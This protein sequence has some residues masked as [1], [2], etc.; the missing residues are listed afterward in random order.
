MPRFIGRLELP[1]DPP[2]FHQLCRV[3]RHHLRR[4]PTDQVVVGLSGGADSLAL[5]AAALAEQVEVHAVCVDHQ[6][7]P[8][9]GAVAEQAAATARHL[10][11]SAEVVRVNVDKRGS[12]EASARRARYA[13]LRQVAAGRP[14]WVGHTGDDQAETLLLRAAR[15]TAAG[16][17]PVAGQVHRPLLPQP[18]SATLAACAEL[19]LTPWQDPQ[20][21]DEA[22]ARVGV[23]RRVI[24]LLAEV[25]GRDVAASLARAAQVAAEDAAALDWLVGKQE[26]LGAE[27][28]GEPVALRRRRI[29]AFLHHH[30]GSV[31][32]ATLRGVD[33]LLTDWHGQGPVAVG[34]GPEGRLVVR[35]SGGQLQVIT[36]GG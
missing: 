21:L 7:Q 23:R 4:Y 36:D 8:G 19:G 5:T 31:N 32:A 20:N 29:A 34:G 6:L 25:F 10:G 2:H 13:A 26:Q 24:P 15:G 35:R 17:L 27:C 3:V 12:L 18:R 14:I 30:G 16:M 9:S 22:F 11:A 28:A 1:K 33:A